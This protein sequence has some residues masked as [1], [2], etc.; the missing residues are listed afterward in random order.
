MTHPT[1]EPSPI[2]LFE[3]LAIH[4]FSFVAMAVMFAFILINI[5]FPPMG[6]PLPGTH[7]C[8]VS[9]SGSGLGAVGTTHHPPHTSL[10]KSGYD[11]S[12]TLG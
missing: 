12:T 5:I 2:I 4:L 8:P 1:P 9:R 6:I 11:R 3:Q 10:L 7:V